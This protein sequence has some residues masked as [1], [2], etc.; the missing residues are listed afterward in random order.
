MAIDLR[1]TLHKLEVLSLVVQLGGVSR[2]AEHLFVAQPVVTAHIRSLEERL[3][4]K[5]FY[6]EGR[7]LHLTDE[8][9]VAHAWA[10]ELLTR[11]RE[12]ERH[13]SSVSD[14]NAGT[15]ALGASMS[16]GSYVLPDVLTG[17][18]KLHRN[19]DLQLSIV[20]TEHAVEETRKGTFDF[21]VVVSD[22]DLDLPGMQVEHI[23][24]DELVLVTA[25]DSEPTGAAV[26]IEEL[27]VLPFIEPA[28]VLRRAH[29]DRLLARLGV[30]DRNVVLQLG[31]PEAMKRAVRNGLGV[32]LLFR[33]AVAD[34]LDAGILR[35]V[36]I[37]GCDFRVPIAVV[38]RRSKVFSP[39]HRQLIEMI[40]QAFPDSDEVSAQ[41]STSPATN[42]AASE[43]GG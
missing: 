1:I 9:R 19:V 21:A 32:A 27:K 34:E 14:G 43:A 28:G 8:G 5:I 12:L 30:S 25:P 7:R 26:Q 35:V 36:A 40:G 13:L 31:H 2:A 23:G 16:V 22:W 3:G 20:D 17:F 18:H 29:S 15:V 33:T 4:I 11:T 41:G 42:E 24:V 37:K 39:L 6:R 38:S 10:E